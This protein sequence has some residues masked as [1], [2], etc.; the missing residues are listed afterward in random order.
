MTTKI[1]WVSTA[2]GL[3]GATWNPVTGC[4]GKP[5]SPAC[6]TCYARRMANRL[7]GRYGYPLDEPFRV[8]LHKDRLAQPLSW[9]KPKVIFVC[10]MADLF[11]PEVPFSFIMAVF[12]IMRRCPQ[13]RF[14]L[15]TKWP[16][17]AV[18]WQETVR[19]LASKQGNAVGI[20]MG[21]QLVCFAA[22][23][24][25]GVPATD[26]LKAFNFDGLWP[27]ANVAFG[28]T[29]ETQVQAD[30]RWR[31]TL[32][33]NAAMHYVSAEPLLGQLS[34]T[35]KGLLGDQRSRSFDLVIVG[36]QTGPKARP[37]HPAWAR[38]LREQCQESGSAYFFKAWGAWVEEFQMTDEAWTG[39]DA[40]GDCGSS[41]AEWLN[42][43][44]RFQ[45]FAPH[46]CY[47]APG[48]DRVFRVGEKAAGHLL[49]GSVVR[50]L[51]AFLV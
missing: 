45:A 26:A 43:D 16:E 28:A 4:P 25:S 35:G 38:S 13:H 30:E 20:S 34:L 19:L 12:D 24:D 36:G 9:R 42:R 8:T 2:A 18:L 22:A 49:D 11:S 17:R 51:P 31:P 21:S 3:R 10:S 33:F 1:E 44:G 47:Y 23:T 41:R 39:V 37:T 14:M 29:M 15:L 6:P 50:S 32:E 48:W 5:G 7:K 27:L 40:L 46:G